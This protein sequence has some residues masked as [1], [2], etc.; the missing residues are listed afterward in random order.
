[1]NWNP[2][3]SYAQLPDGMKQIPSYWKVLT[4]PVPPEKG[5]PHFRDVRISSLTSVGAKP[6]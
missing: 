2:S 3:Y 6:A 4:E 5:L 1:M